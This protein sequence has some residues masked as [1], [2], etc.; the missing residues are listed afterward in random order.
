MR[1][2]RKE[3]VATGEQLAAEPLRARIQLLRSLGG[4]QHARRGT[5]AM[6]RHDLERE[7]CESRERQ[8]ASAGHYTMQG[9]AQRG[10][11]RQCNGVARPF[12]DTRLTTRR[13]KVTPLFFPT[14]F[15]TFFLFPRNF[16]SV[17]P[18]WLVCFAAWRQNAFSLFGQSAGNFLRSVESGAESGAIIP[19]PNC[20]TSSDW[21]AATASAAAGRAMEMHAP[22]GGGLDDPF[23]GAF[24]FADGIL[25][26]KSGGAALVVLLRCAWLTIAFRRCR[27]G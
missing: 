7:S 27:W 24:G 14:F 11:E 13:K 2:G 16:P 26:F 5:H 8:D 12:G 20:T 9:G 19:G 1:R 21:L 15:F 22:L 17:I 6:S 4:I 25:S 23:H 18:D 10:K 3:L